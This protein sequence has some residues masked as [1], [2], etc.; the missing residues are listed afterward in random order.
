[1]RFLSEFVQFVKEDT[2]NTDLQTYTVRNV[3]M[4][5]EG[6][7]TDSEGRIANVTA[8]QLRRIPLHFAELLKRGFRPMLRL[9]HNAKHAL[10]G[11]L[12]GLGTP[13]NLRVAP[14][15]DGKGLSL[16][17]DLMR[18]P[19]IIADVMK[20][21]GYDSFSA[22]L[23]GDLT[24][25]DYT[26][27]LALHHMALLGAEHPA[28]AA[29]QHVT[30]LPRLYGMSGG[31]AAF[32]IVR[33]AMTAD[34]G[35]VPVGRMSYLFCDA[36]EAVAEEGGSKVDDLKALLAKRGL[37]SVTELE[38]A[39]DEN[40]QLK[41]RNEALT[42]SLAARDK[43]MFEERAKAFIGAHRKK[44]KPKFDEGISLVVAKLAADETAYTFA[45]GEGKK[46]EMDAVDVLSEFVSQLPDAADFSEHGE[47]D[48]G[49]SAD[50]TRE[51]MK[52]EEGAR[53]KKEKEAE[54]DNEG[55]GSEDDF[56]MPTMNDDAADKI[57]E[58]ARELIKQ[59]R[60]EGRSLSRAD[61]LAD[62]TVQLAREERGLVR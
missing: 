22:G 41:E 2:E 60:D 14:A 7:H 56:T 27:D 51:E 32:A 40:A 39:L 38:V 30:D 3:E 9:T 37:T 52:K 47:D 8:E 58:R 20:V 61:A 42:S 29:L 36:G 17:G 54:D 48:G 28:I 15:S 59:A 57:E 49:A 35:E 5:K 31:E 62:A 19:K 10:L 12:P 33:E 50:E 11:G 34:F 23:A 46:V 6:R 16:W 44:I 43:R 18:V 26:A 53:K 24:V 45:R 55:S 1:M 13:F 25:G 21:G 4:F